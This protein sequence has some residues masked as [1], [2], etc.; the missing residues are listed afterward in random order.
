MAVVQ[1]ETFVLTDQ[2]AAAIQAA[3]S[4]RQASV[5][6]Q[7]PALRIGQIAAPIII[8]GTVIAVDLIWYDGTLPA[9]LIFTVVAAFVAGMLF[10]TLAYKLTLELMKRRLRETTHQ[11]VAPR[12]VRLTDEG[13][14]QTLPD[15]RSLQAWSGIDRADETSGLIHRVGGQSDD[16]GDTG[17]VLPLRSRRAGLSHGVPAARRSARRADW[18]SVI[19][20]CWVSS[21]RAAIRFAL[22]PY[23]LTTCSTPPSTQY[24]SPTGPSQTHWPIRSATPCKANPA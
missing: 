8:I 14:E 9:W 11:L 2:E 6:N 19:R 3:Q 17:Q 16:R 12:S 4:A 24:W 10:Q 15:V 21:G 20:H 13:I 7:S 1:P 23:E 18:R 5:A 22:A